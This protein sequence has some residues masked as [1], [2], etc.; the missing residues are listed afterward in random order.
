MYD[1]SP[2]GVLITISSLGRFDRVTVKALVGTRIDIAND[3][4]TG[5]YK[6]YA[7]FVYTDEFDRF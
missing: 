6:N 5:F 1:R 3:G 4:F 7:I 2:D